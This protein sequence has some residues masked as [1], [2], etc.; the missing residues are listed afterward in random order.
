MTASRVLVVDDEPSIVELVATT[1]RYEGHEVATAATGR[2]ALGTAAWF[3]PHL[4]LLDVMLPDIDGF[5][6]HEGLDTVPVI[7]LTARASS[8]DAVRGLTL[9]ADD[10]VTKPFSL[11]EL[12]ARVRAVL[13]RILRD[14][15]S[16]L[17]TYADVVLDENTHE[18]R[19]DGTVLELTRTEYELL[20]YLLLNPR[21]VL[22]KAQIL[23]HV[24]QYD[25][26]GRTNI[27]EL[28]ISYLRRKIDAHGPPLIHTV[29]SVGYILRQAAA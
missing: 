11:E 8:G 18:V 24:W 20:R 26:Q 6:V 28:Y 19:R 12:V 13:R 17:I 15:S 1:L 5:A 23:D 2:E 16:S 10:Y 9:G 3:K 25:F 27:V 4:V 22:S 14:G 7:Y 21:R 29:R